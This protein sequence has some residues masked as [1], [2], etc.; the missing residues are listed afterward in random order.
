MLLRLI[1]PFF[2]ILFK[3]KVLNYDF[4]LTSVNFSYIRAVKHFAVEFLNNTRVSI[5]IRAIFDC[6]YDCVDCNRYTF[7]LFMLHETHFGQKFQITRKSN[8]ARISVN[9]TVEFS[10]NNKKLIGDELN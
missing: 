8:A 2:D 9:L 7:V 6:D 5:N 1:F 10:R 4:D 3:K